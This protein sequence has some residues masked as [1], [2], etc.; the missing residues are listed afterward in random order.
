MSLICNTEKKVIISLI[1]IGAYD[2]EGDSGVVRDQLETRL[3]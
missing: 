1:V 2:E 3:G